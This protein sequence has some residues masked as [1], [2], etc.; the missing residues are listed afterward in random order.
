[1]FEVVAEVP[2]NIALIKY[3]GKRDSGRQWPA[4]DSLSMTLSAACTRTR[5][6]LAESA[7]DSLIWDGP[8]QAL[9]PAATAKALAH[10][11]RLRRETGYAA[12]LA[13]A[14]RNTF[15]T[16]CGIASSASG[17]GALTVAAL[18]AWTGAESLTD[19]ET[20]GY[21]AERLAALARLGSGSACR[22]LHGGYVLWEAKDAP[23]TQEVRAV[24]SSDAWPLA[25]LI[26]LVEPT[27]KAVGSSAGHKGAWTSPLFAPRLA[28]LA[29][30][31]AAVRAAL[32]RRD[33]AA[34]GLAVE[35]EALEMHAVMLS[36]AE[37]LRYL[38]EPTAAVLAWIRALRRRVGIGAY[39]TL[40]AGPNVHVLCE[41]KDAATVAARLAAAFPRYE[42]LL[43][44]TGPGP[45][46]RRSSS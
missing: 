45:T 2:A 13:L 23:E 36:A 26:V 11:V 6:R 46:L 24:A 32:E 1:M 35:A 16:G 44:R 28:G 3:W 41:P 21:G 27:E 19:L 30:R 34:L 18:A 17:M 42:L 5:A 29:E 12:P 15:P 8:G 20:A 25:D 38:G 10:V 37:P 31:L 7:A 22:S 4:N 40:D 33:L 39:F 14:T 43:D 9:A